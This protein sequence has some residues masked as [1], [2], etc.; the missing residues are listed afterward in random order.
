MLSLDAALNICPL[1]GDPTNVLDLATGTGIWATAFAQQHPKSNVLGVDLSAV[2][3]ATDLPNCKFISADITKD[4]E[5]SLAAGNF[6]YIHSRT[7][8][9][10]M[11]DWKT[12]FERCYAALSPGGWF[13]VQEVLWPVKSDRQPPFES[14]QSPYIRW[15]H[16]LADGSAKLGIDSSIPRLFKV[17][18]EDAGF[19][20]VGERWIRWPLGPWIQDEKLKQVGELIPSATLRILRPMTMRVLREETGW[21]AEE[22]EKI[23]EGVRKDLGSDLLSKRYYIPV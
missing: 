10:F 11:R 8:L 7:I 21:E 17:M 22:V 5:K 12:Y 19:L 2:E 6:D 14:D 4:W 20:D 13:E 16:A 1:Q 3:P 23:M 15:S 9:A 18:M